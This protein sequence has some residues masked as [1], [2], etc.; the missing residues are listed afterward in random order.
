M[1]LFE[2]ECVECTCV[3]CGC[4]AA[5]HRDVS[6]FRKQC[7]TAG[8]STSDPDYIEVSLK[9]LTCKIADS[10]QLLK[11]AF[12]GQ[13]VVLNARLGP[14]LVHWFI[15][16]IDIWYCSGLLVAQILQ[17]GHRLPKC[18]H[19]TWC[20]VEMEVLSVVGVGQTWATVISLTCCTF[21]FCT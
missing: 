3:E 10:V 16:G 1:L 7:S 2:P 5:E 17:T 15:L 18:H 8:L 6:H 12:F 9:Q 19:C 11:L 4:V 14:V 13:D 20:A 21:N